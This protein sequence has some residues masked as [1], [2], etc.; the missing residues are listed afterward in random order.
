[1]PTDAR[2]VGSVDTFCTVWGGQGADWQPHGLHDKLIQGPERDPVKEGEG[3]I[4]AK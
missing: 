3:I 1:M 2:H 4:K